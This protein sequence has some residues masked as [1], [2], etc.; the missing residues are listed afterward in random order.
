[1]IGDSLFFEAVIYVIMSSFCHYLSSSI[2]I[3]AQDANS[4]SKLLFLP[5]LTGE[6]A[7]FK[8]MISL[9]KNAT[10]E[11]IGHFMLFTKALTTSFLTDHMAN[12]SENV[13]PKLRQ[14]RLKNVLDE[15]FTA[16]IDELGFLV[17]TNKLDFTRT[18]CFGKT[19]GC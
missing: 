4:P 1:V 14:S 10:P 3:P 2:I 5:G 9:V 8:P 7:A 19:R 6:K 11:S 18:N 15:M 17:S 16:A 13:N 12:Y